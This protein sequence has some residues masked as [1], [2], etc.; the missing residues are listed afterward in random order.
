MSLQNLVYSETLQ[1]ITNLL[2]KL[3]FKHFLYLLVHFMQGDGEGRKLLRAYSTD[4]GES[5]KCLVKAG[6]TINTF[7]VKLTF[8]IYKLPPYPE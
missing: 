3:E 7:A 1:R 5:K 4:R 8:V 2:A 6:P